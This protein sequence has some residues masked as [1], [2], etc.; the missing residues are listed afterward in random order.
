MA[1][2]KTNTGDHIMPKFVDY[3]SDGEVRDI[4]ESIANR[5]PTMFEGFDADG[6]NFVTTKKK[7]SHKPLKL[8]T[9]GYPMQVFI[10]KPYIVECF[11]TKWKTLDQKRKNLAVFHIMCGIPEG[12]FDEQ[13]KHYGKKVKPE[14]EMYLME[15]AA[16]GGV[17]NWMDNP[18][19]SD[20]MEQT[21]DD[22]SKKV[23][24]NIEAIPE[25]GEEGKVIRIPVTPQAVASVRVGRKGS[26]KVAVSA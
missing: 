24:G 25:E 18:E 13:S 4:M 16:A 3:Y 10:G 26:G 7:K 21:P 9:I 20:P 17:P 11:D 12:G 1:K 14:I 8:R 23:P 15:Y 5:F 22:V 6:I 2:S 19:A